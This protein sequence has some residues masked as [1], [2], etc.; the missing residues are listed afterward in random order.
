MYM[1]ASWQINTYS[2]NC[3]MKYLEITLIK[4]AGSLVFKMIYFSETIFR[5]EQASFA[6][7]NSVYHFNWNQK[8]L[9]KQDAWHM[10]RHD[11]AKGSAYNRLLHTGS[12]L[13][14]ESCLTLGT[15][16]TVACQALCPW[17]FPGKNTAV[18]CHFLLQGS[19]QPRDQTPVSC[20]AG[21]F[22]TDWVTYRDICYFWFCCSLCLFNI[23]ILRVLFFTISIKREKYMCHDFIIV[24]TVLLTIFPTRRTYTLMRTKFLI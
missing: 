11:K 9:S 23:E 5:K 14:T 17:Y 7:G 4:Y 20:N 13:V 10:L 8:T 18:G 2:V 15:P 16:W 21:R 6:V 24:N 12:G 19:S 3:S 1:E 22:F